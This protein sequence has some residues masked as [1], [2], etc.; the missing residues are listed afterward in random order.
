[1]ITTSLGETFLLS[2]LAVSLL[3]LSLDVEARADDC[4]VLPGL[5]TWDR[6]DG[7]SLPIQGRLD[8]C[9]SV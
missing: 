8:F 6:I 9:I 1:M 5:F 4:A 2:H 3:Y 7:G